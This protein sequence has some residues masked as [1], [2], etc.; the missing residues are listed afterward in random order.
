MKYTSQQYAKALYDSLKKSDEEGAGLIFKNFYNVLLR[1]NDLGLIN[2][3]IE[4]IEEIDKKER[5]IVE[6][7][8]DS[9]NKL[10]QETQDKL[11]NLMGDKAQ[12]KERVN[13]RLIGGL[14]IQIDDLLIDGSIRGKLDKL[15]RKLA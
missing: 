14:K 15:K 5:N 9:A 11:R 6:V 10:T 8:I 1:N 13:P 12:I 4:K 3:I 7:K 2:K